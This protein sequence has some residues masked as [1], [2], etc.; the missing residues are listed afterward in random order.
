MDTQNEPQPSSQ[1]PEVN[2][3]TNAAPVPNGGLPGANQPPATATAPPAP[4]EQAPTPPAGSG[5]ASGGLPPDSTPPGQPPTSP[6]PPPSGASGEAPKKSKKLPMLIL[7]VIIILVVL[8]GGFYFM[9]HQQKKPKPAA[10]IKVGLMM[11]FSGGS[12][13]MGFGTSKG[14]ALAKKALNANNITVVQADSKCDP[15]AALKAV[16]QLVQQ[17]VAAIIGDGCSSASLAA[18][19]IANN[20][21]IPMISPSASS[22]KLS[23][24]NDYF[25]RVIPNDNQQGAFMAETVYNKGIKKTA[26]FYTNEPYGASIQQAFQDKYESLGG[27]VVA[28]AIAQPNV[29]NIS[30]QIASL[31]AAHPDAIFFAPNSVTSGIA[32][33]KLAHQDGIKV[34]YF[35]ADVFYDQSIITNAADAVEGMTF[36]TFPTGTA[37]FKQS[38]ATAYPNDGQLY[39]A[40]E[41]YDAFKAIYLATQKGASTGQQIKNMLPSIKFTGVSADNVSFNQFGD[42]STSGTNYKYA[43]FN[44]KGGKFE[45]LN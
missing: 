11:A 37:A 31:K 29:I 35:G 45:Q 43:L 32:A 42:L 10:N 21:Q 5:P 17:H 36:T 18:L 24:P 2:N 7:I 14:V 9:K 22:T 13:A 1:V 4:V 6:T 28:T 33:V 8:G 27:K 34:P 40:P 39:A 30:T 15:Q 12:S 23:I 41:S 25:F 16:N 44:V 19:P 26:I 3:N 20:N 38:V